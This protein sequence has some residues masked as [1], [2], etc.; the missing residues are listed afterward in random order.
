[1]KNYKISQVNG[2]EMIVTIIAIKNHIKQLKSE[3][4]DVTQLQEYLKRLEDI[5]Y[6]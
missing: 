5:Y 4:K 1:M 3:H 2:Y 6:N